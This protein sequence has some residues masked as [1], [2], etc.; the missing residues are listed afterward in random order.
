LN[1]T[2]FGYNIFI[3]GS[4][5]NC[6]EINVTLNENNQISFAKIIQIRSGP[7]C[8]L[9]TFLEDGDTVDFIKASLQFCQNEFPALKEIEFDDA[10]YI[11]CDDIKKKIDNVKQLLEKPISGGARKCAVLKGEK[12][13]RKIYVV[14]RERCIRV[15]GTFI[16][17]KAIKGRYNIL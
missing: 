10:S 5:Y 1:K 16:P 6:I 11:D 14:N 17:L 12:R 4:Y 7:E 3:G 8:G 9:S 13:R 2:K 15:D